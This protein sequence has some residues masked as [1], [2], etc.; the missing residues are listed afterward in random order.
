LQQ[1]FLTFLLI[2]NQFYRQ[3]NKHAVLACKKIFNNLHF[4]DRFLVLLRRLPFFP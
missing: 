1:V 3:A 2:E 4:W